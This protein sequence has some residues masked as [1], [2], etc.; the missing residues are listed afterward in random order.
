MRLPAP[1]RVV[2]ADDHRLFRQGLCLLLEKTR[3]VQVLGEASNGEEAVLQARERRPDVLLLDVDMPIMDGVSAAKV[4]ARR[5]GAP[6]IVLL[7]SFE[8]DA[9]IRAG[10]QAGAA[11]YVPKRVDVIELVSIMKGILSG[12]LPISPFLVN[13]ALEP[14]GGAREAFRRLTE[15]ERLVLRLL[16]EGWSNR[17]ISQKAYMSRDT[18]KVYLKS[19]FQK[20]SVKN[21]TQ[22]AVL[23]VQAGWCSRPPAVAS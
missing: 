8:D 14:G 15:R 9:R 2:I 16:A 17:E 6:K 22:A 10:M 11:G 3:E 7:S 13:Q 1:I 18:V 21:R 23:A 19:I 5:P 20:L 12:N 4:L